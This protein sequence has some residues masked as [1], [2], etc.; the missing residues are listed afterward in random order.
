MLN[1]VI[2]KAKLILED[3]QFGLDLAKNWDMDNFEY[4]YKYFSDNDKE[5]RKYSLLV[6]AAGLENWLSGSAT[7]FSEPFKTEKRYVFE[8]YIQSFIN[9]R[10][11][12]SSDFPSLYNHIVVVLFELEKSQKLDSIFKTMSVEVSND[13]KKFLHDT[14]RKSLKYF[15]YENVL[16]EISMNDY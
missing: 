11:T 1:I 14:D 9:N 7:V 3:I 8:D 10:V 5:V 15:D 4:F 16:R 2:D 13:F 12:I 6:F